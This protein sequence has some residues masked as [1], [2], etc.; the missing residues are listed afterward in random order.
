MNVRQNYIWYIVSQKTLKKRYNSGFL[1]SLKIGLH[2]RTPIV[3]TIKL[4]SLSKKRMLDTL[5]FQ[6]SMVNCNFYCHVK[7]C[8]LESVRMRICVAFL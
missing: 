3:A 1:G 2:E 5:S 8:I 4:Y 6:S 7:K